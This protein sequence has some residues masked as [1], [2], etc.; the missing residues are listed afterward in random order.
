M[1]G[2]VCEVQIS[3]ERL[4]QMRAQKLFGG[5]DAFATFRFVDEVLEWYEDNSRRSTGTTPFGSPKGMRAT[6]LVSASSASIDEDHE[7]G[8][9]GDKIGD[10]LWNMP[11]ASLS[12]P[13]EQRKTS[14]KASRT[15][16]SSA[17]NTRKISN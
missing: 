14:T 9:G 4:Y 3:H 16:A 2:L 17:S 1:G 12:P 7:D 6:S 5:H 11:F 15:S 8:K 13:G 10:E